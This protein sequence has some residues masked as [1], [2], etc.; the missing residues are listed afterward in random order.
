MLHTIPPP[1]L[2]VPHTASASRT[3][4]A[5]AREDDVLDRWPLVLI[6]VYAAGVALLL[7]RRWLGWRH[8][9]G[10]A[11]QATPVSI[12]GA[13]RRLDDRGAIAIRESARLVAPV[14][15]GL[16]QPVVLLPIDWR[17]WPPG[18]IRAVVAHETAHARRRDPLVNAIAEANRCV[19][20]FHPL[21]WWLA[22][23]IAAAAEHA[24][25][26][27][28]IG[29]TGD[30][31]CYAATLVATARTVRAH[32]GRIVSGIGMHGGGLLAERIDRALDG[33]LQERC[34]RRCGI[35]VAAG[36]A[37]ALL[38]AVGCRT[39]PAHA[40]AFD[41]GVESRDRA[42]RAAIREIADAPLADVMRDVSAPDSHDVETLEAALRRNPD[43]VDARRRLLIAR[44]VQPVA[45][46]AKR[47]DAILRLIERHPESPL[48]GS[49]EAR[50]FAHRVDQSLDGDAAGYARAKAI[51]LAHAER[52]DAPA[53]VLVNASLFVEASEPSLAEQL[54]LRGRALH[55]RG[56]WSLRLGRLYAL[57]LKG[58]T[59]PS[60][61]HRRL[62]IAPDPRGAFATLVRGTLRDTADDVLLTAT[63]WFLARAPQL[64]QTEFD[65]LQWADTSLRRAIALNPNAIFAHTTLLRVRTRQEFARQPLW[66]VAPAARYRTV[67][68]L[69]ED[70]RF[71]QLARHAREAHADAEALMRWSDDP[72]LRERLALARDDARRYASD[73]LRLAPRHRADPQY[74]TAIY[75]ANMTLGALALDEGRTADAIEFLRRASRAPASEE[76]IYA[77]D[78][79]VGLHW[80]L[81][82]D[83]LTRGERDAVAAFADRMA[84]V[85]LARRSELRDAA[86]AIRRGDTPR[87]FRQGR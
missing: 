11:A 80:R 67:S 4:I 82:S 48:A 39:E 42:M 62:L 68:A 40:I 37:T 41:A 21:A 64:P 72:N 38:V 27:A 52:A 45:D 60:K 86:A 63:G 16:V 85:S 50:L 59:A 15:V 44:W 3:F 30:R 22:R 24:S 20:W 13:G 70:E 55:P 81:A 6:A 54:L 77:D 28:A 2:A 69:P 35:A 31:E 5:P 26:A 56:P 76:L 23:A 29:A 18:A 47:R 33:H 78:V 57:V 43:D 17:G 75:V 73:A 51:W 1:P 14:T 83:L 61:T 71:A 58:F 12:D 84:Q 9:T 74:G 10:I 79:V 65:T 7:T 19:F 25:D 34:S 87:I 53:A 49:V 66:Q 46:G 36:C 8:A 32:G